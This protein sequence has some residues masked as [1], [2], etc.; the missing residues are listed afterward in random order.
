MLVSVGVVQV[1]CMIGSSLRYHPTACAL[2]PHVKNST[3][4]KTFQKHHGYFML[5]ELRGLDP[6]ARAQKIFAIYS[7]T[8]FAPIYEHRFG[9]G[10]VAQKLGG[11]EWRWWLIVEADL[12][13]EYRTYLGRFDKHISAAEAA[14]QAV[15]AAREWWFEKEID[16]KF[17]SS[18]AY[19]RNVE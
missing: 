10:N 13:R 9:P 18:L 5:D 7:T 3:A 15:D 11:F 2:F 19:S 4:L 14:R 1:L 8:L 16:I 6:P 17:K 12:I